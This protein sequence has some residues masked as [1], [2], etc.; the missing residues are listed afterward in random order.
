MLSVSFMENKVKEFL[1]KLAVYT[2]PMYGGLILTGILM[3]TIGQQ[4]GAGFA[5]G[6]AVTFICL[7]LNR[8]VE[9]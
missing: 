5:L 3:L 9:L 4:Y 8:M 6:M 7:T 2:Y 1:T